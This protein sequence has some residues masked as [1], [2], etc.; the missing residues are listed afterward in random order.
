M[1]NGKKRGNFSILT[2]VPCSG[3]YYYFIYIFMECEH[4]GM[5]LDNT[6]CRNCDRELYMMEHASEFDESDYT[7]DVYDRA[8]Y[9]RSERE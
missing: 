1:T 3:D 7:D 9:Q 4:C 2:P 8:E 6:L 5:L